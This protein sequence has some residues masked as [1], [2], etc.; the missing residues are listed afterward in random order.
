MDKVPRRRQKSRVAMSGDAAR[1]SA[2]AA[3][4]AQAFSRAMGPTVAFTAFR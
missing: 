4:A 1:T 2:C 3:K